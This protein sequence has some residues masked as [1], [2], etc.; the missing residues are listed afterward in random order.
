MTACLWITRQLDAAAGVELPELD[1]PDEDDPEDDPDDVD[2]D[3]ESL[4][5]ELDESEDPLDVEGALSLL[6]AEL[7]ALLD[8]E[9]S[10]LS[11]R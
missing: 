3:F 11:L 8:F 2:D 10:R 5:E 7:A 9:A 6:L 4:D 1:D